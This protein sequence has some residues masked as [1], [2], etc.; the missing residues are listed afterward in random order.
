MHLSF[1]GQ[2][3]DHCADIIDDDI[4]DKADLTG[5]GID[6]HLADVAAIREGGAL[7]SIGGVLVQPRLHSGRQA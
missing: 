7:R 4:G 2:R 5:L 6:F 1:E 3:I